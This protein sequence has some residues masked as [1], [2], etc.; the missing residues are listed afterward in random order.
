MLKSLLQL[1]R[2]RRAVLAVVGNGMLSLATLLLSVAVARESS[3]PGFS[4]FSLAMVS[5]L[6]LSGLVR[7]SFTDSALSRPNEMREYSVS[8]QRAS[9]VALGT[10]G[11]L[12]LWGLASQNQFLSILG[13][14]LHGLIT[15]DFI[16]AFETAAGRAGRALTVC[17]AWSLLTL[18]V[19]G[20]SLMAPFPPAVVF[21]AWC[22]SG[23]VCGYG[24]LAAARLPIVPRWARDRRA[25]RVASFFGLDYLVGSGGSLLT[26]ALLG[27][28]R[29]EGV[30]AA[31]RGAGTLLGPINLLSTT[32]RSLLLPY[33]AARMADP[34]AQFLAALRA[35]LTQAL[36][37]IPL[38]AALQFVPTPVGEQL[39]GPTWE[40]AALALLP[41][42]IEALFA[43]I[44]AVPA[45]GHRVAFAGKR[46][47]TLRLII[48]VPRPM[49]VLLSA[50]HW[51]VSGAA[52]AMAI[53]S[54]FNAG[55]WWKS[56]Y[57][58]THPTGA[59]SI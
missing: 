29:P 43:L 16:R 23:A 37:I 40:V 50:S 34:P 28:T 13:L 52:W 30:I 57:S 6:F 14:A 55:L 35:T 20:L 49:I 4:A 58:L 17:L 51:G 2:S 31:V 18:A 3:I 22:A 45:A 48:G 27:F 33:L 7:A 10:G 9:A 25:T 24:L 41:M 44:S 53:I 47:L 39:L 36:V 54:V 15:L 38:L 8:F 12:F 32:A 19:S 1:L 21:G 46:T 59:A 42:S 56:Y 5:Y 26:T 11:V